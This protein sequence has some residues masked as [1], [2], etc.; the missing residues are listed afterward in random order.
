MLLLIGLLLVGLS[1]IGYGIYN[2]VPMSPILKSL[3]G[4]GLFFGFF[5]G[6]IFV[7][8]GFAGAKAS[9]SKSREGGSTT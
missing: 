5:I 8:L 7:G 2:M 3:L 6:F 9:G 4:I 1:I